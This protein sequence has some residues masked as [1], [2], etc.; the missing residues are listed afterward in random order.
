MT[1]SIDL[2]SMK[3][4]EIIK[5]LKQFYNKDFKIDEDLHWNITFE[6]P[7]EMVDFIGS[8]IDNNDKFQI[9]MWICLDEDVLINVN[10]T[11]ANN[12]IKY[13]FERYPY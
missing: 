1:T 6:N 5:F 2:F 13:L 12:I 11:N 8:F 10:N 3:K 7:I 4:G 9:T